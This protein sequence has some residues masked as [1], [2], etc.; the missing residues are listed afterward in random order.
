[1]GDTTV[2]AVAPVPAVVFDTVLRP[3]RS[4]VRS[5]ALSI[6]FSAV[7]LAV[8]LVWVSFPF[9][10]WA[11]F[12]AVVV[13]MAA[14]VGVVFVRLHTAFIGI[15][16]DGLT[17]RGVLTGRRRIAR[18]R[19]HSLVLATT[20]GSSVDRTVRELVAFDRTGTHLFRLRADVWG[21]DGLDRVVD[22]L[23]V[24]V[25]EESRPVSARTFA[26]RYPTSRAWYEQRSAYLLIGGLTALVVGGLL[27]VEFAG[28]SAR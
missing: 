4:L 23:G 12:A 13:A 17:I 6:A 20:F 7:P 21:D 1:M 3:R 11:V 15:D 19:V 25:V 18:D 9:R 24:Q 28:L 22:A 5:T 16:G 14:V 27:A 8:A 2:P 26:K 10:T